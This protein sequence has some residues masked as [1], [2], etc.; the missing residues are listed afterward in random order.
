MD[1]NTKYLTRKSS[2]HL[3]RTI[4][5]PSMKWFR[6]ELNLPMRRQLYI[7]VQRIHIATMSKASVVLTVMVRAA[8]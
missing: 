3:D 7:S 6:L 2:G 4:R 8:K 1:R 5:W